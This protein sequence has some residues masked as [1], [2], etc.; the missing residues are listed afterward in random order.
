[1]T[2]PDGADAAALRRL[3]DQ[4]YL[5]RY[6]H[7]NAAADVQI[8]VLHS[9]ATLHMVRPDIVRLANHGR[10]AAAAAVRRRPVFFVEEDRFIDTA[11]HDR[12]ALEPGFSGS[13]PA[14]IVEYGSSTLIGPR[15]T[16]RIGSLGEIDIDCS[17]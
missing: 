17:R 15:D 1:V 8:V 16:F 9:L 5:R 2:V 12:Y 13:G 10:R 4:E 3:F 6:G 7:A 14:L 11:I